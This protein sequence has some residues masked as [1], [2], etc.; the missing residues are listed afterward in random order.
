MQ[1]SWTKTN[2]DKAGGQLKPVTGAT[3]CR[4]YVPRWHTIGVLATETA[5]DLPLATTQELIGDLQREDAFVTGRRYELEPSRG[6][7]AGSSGQGWKLSKD[8]LLRKGAALY[9]PGSP[10]LR[11]EILAINHDDPYSG[12]FGFARTL[13]L[14]R[15]KYFWPGM[16]QEI[17]RYVKTCPVCQRTK[18]KRHRPYGELA[19]FQPPTRPWQEITMDFIVGLP[20]SKFRGK[21]YDSILVVV[22]RFTKMARYVPVNATI[23]AR[24]LAEVFINT[25]FKD[26]GTPRGITSDRGPQFTSQ[27]WGHFMFCLNIRRRLSTA[28]RPQTDGQTERQNQT[29]EHYLRCYCNYAQDDWGPKLALAEFSYN[30]SVHDSTGKAPFYLLYGY[31]PEIDVEDTVPVEGDM[32]AQRRVEKL[33]DE[34]KELTDTLRRAIESHKKHYDRK[35]APMRFR[36]GDRVMLAAKNIKQLRPNRKLADKFL[37]PFT[38]REVV[39]GHSQAYRLELPSAYRIHDVF[40]VSLLE[41]YHSRADTIVDPVTG[42]EGHEEWEVQ[43]IQTHKDTRA[44]RRYLVRWKGYSPAEDTWEP[45]KHLANAQDVLRSYHATAPRAIW[46]R[47]KRARGRGRGRGRGY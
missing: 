46:T 19:P 24:E 15:R 37:G 3:V 1:E 30:N 14:V 31:V 18:T 9:V 42:T 39:G 8:G 22:D 27:F 43:A 35:H 21:V 45:P 2:C 36:I 40:H 17:K 5:Y 33:Q 11:A 32:A 7:H 13:E 28:F 4:L 6:R 20:P 12:H 47:G 44:G 38:V 23:D 16:R 25:I 10:A 29:L 26:Y 34:R 41:P